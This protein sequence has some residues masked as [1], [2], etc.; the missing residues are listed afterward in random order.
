MK[1]Y[2]QRMTKEVRQG[3]GLVCV[4]LIALL[5]SLA[6]SEDIGRF[7]RGA[8]LLFGVGGLI[9]IAVGLFRRPT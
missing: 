2:G 6:A 8:A 1:G 9:I 3:L 4:A 5:V 7:L